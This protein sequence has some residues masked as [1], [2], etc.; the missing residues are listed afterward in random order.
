MAMYYTG[1]NNSASRESTDKARHVLDQEWKNRIYNGQFVV[2]TYANQEGEK[3]GNGQGVAS[4]LQTIVTARFSLAFD[5]AKGL[6]ENQLKLTQAKSSAKSGIMQSTSG[7]MVGVEKHI[8]PTAWK[9]EKY[10]ETQSHLPISKIKIEVDTLIEVEFDTC[11]QTLPPFLDRK[12]PWRE[13]AGRSE[14][15][16]GKIRNRHQ[17]RAFRAL[18]QSVYAV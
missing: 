13:Q 6:T 15:A 16:G 2:Y 4:V 10:W 5:F 7:V 18:L 8:L 9:V 11:A 14:K 12:R 17:G 1:N 3:L